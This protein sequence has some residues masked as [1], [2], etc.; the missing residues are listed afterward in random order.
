MSERPSG[1]TVGT[2]LSER[3]R[4]PEPKPPERRPR[5]TQGEMMPLEEKGERRKGKYKRERG[6]TEKSEKCKERT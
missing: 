5:W 2:S 6:E 3:M 1:T 4:S